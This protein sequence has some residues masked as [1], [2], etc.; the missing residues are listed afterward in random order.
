EMAPVSSHRAGS[1]FA[2]SDIE[3][4]VFRVA[5]FS[6]VLSLTAAPHASL[7][8]TLWCQS[9]DVP[10]TCG[11]HHLS[12]TTVEG[13]DRCD[14]TALNEFSFVGEEG[15]GVAGASHA[16]HAVPVPRYWLF[17]PTS[18]RHTVEDSERAWALERRPLKTP[19]RL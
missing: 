18:E 10:T 14:A 13:D 3:R 6:I 4:V 9:S 7:L 15:P 8:C 11:H 5:L 12:S 2:D 1:D 17:R 16:A 19:L